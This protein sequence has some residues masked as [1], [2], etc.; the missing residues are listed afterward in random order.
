[1][2]SVSI[3]LPW[4]K[5]I[6]CYEHEEITSVQFESSIEKNVL[7]LCDC[8]TD[9]ICVMKSMHKCSSICPLH[10]ALIYAWCH[11]MKLS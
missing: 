5:L 11:G 6:N 9:S 1:M 8:V 3:S 2:Q 7:L 4:W 10:L